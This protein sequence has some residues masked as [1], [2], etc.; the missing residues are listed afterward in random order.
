MKP[1]QL[2]KVLKIGIPQRRAFLLVG[3]PGIGKTDIP[4]QVAAAIDYDCQIFHPV[5]S[6]PT[7]FKGMPWIYTDKESNEAKAEFIPFGDLRRLLESTKPTLAFLDDLGQAPPLVQAATMQLLLARRINGHV[8]PDHVTFLAATNRREDKAAIS[9]ILEPVKSR[10]LSIINLEVDVEDWIVWAIKNDL[11]PVIRAF[12]RYRPNL[13]FDFKPT[14]DMTNSPLPRTVAHVAK[15]Y[16]DKY[17]SDVEYELYSGA[18]GEG[19][20]VEFL[21]FAK[22]FRK[23]VSPKKVI[24]DPDSI[25]IPSDPAVLYALC[26]A[27]ANLSN[28]SDMG[29]IVRFAERLSDKSNFQDEMARSEFAVLLVRDSCNHDE[30]CRNTREYIEWQSKNPDIVV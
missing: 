30:E 27:V 8:V 13:L 4:T 11:A 6:D 20:A 5:V 16:K 24:A 2:F 10:F 7:D 9:G 26:S 12:I 19:F 3:G 18:A 17:P 28:D 25:T 29:S 14:G 15:L 21:A 23:L 1:S 22:I